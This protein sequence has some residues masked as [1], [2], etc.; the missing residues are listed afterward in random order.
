VHALVWGRRD[1]ERTVLCVHGYSGNA[2]DF[3]D[4]ARGL[5]DDTRV[6]CID[7]AGR[8]ESAWLAPMEY[9]FGQFMADIRAL[10][11]HLQVGEV[12][13][14]GTSMGGLLGMMIASQ[15][16][17]PIRRL[18]INDVGAYLPAEALARIGR[19]LEA[20]AVFASLEEVEAHLRHSH[21]DWGP[22]TEPQWKRLVRH[23]VRRVE[24]GYALHFDPQIARIVRPMPYAPGLYFWDSWYRVRCPVM[25]LRGEHSEVLPRHVARTMQQSR[26]DTRIEEIA[27]CGHAPSLMAQGQI[28][29][30]RDF[31]SAAARERARDGAVS[32]G[33]RHEPRQPL[34]SPG[35][36]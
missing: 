17:S 23:G 25:L 13:L 12:D 10:L 21:R 24:G 15:A 4:L 20:P 22:I 35:P 2:R 9:H 1:S 30:V 19:N 3:D 32:S 11:A 18:V 36:A 28:A 29:L 14:V 34:H 16:S 8:G 6:I 31:L 5:S 33:A 26:P 27:G 7:V